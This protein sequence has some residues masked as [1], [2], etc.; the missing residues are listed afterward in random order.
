MSR[1]R[2][3]PFT[4]LLLAC[5]GLASVAPARGAFNDAFGVATSVTIAL[6]FFLH[7]ARLS[8]ATVI[9]GLTHW[10]LHLLVFASTFVLFPILGLAIGLF[11]PELLSPTLYAGILFLCALPSTV[12]SSIAF[13]SIARGNV[14]AAVCSAS[15]S[16][17][18]GIFLTPVLVSVLFSKHG[19]GEIS[20]AAI[21]SIMLQLL[22]PFV[23]GQIC[24]ARLSRL[25]Q[26]YKDLTGIVDRGSILMVVYL[27]FSNA[28]VGGL[29]QKLSVQSIAM[30]ALVDLALLL[31]VVAVTM[32][33]SRLLGFSKEDEITIVFCGSKKS[34]ASGL[35]MAAALFAGQDLGAIVLPLMIFHQIQ[36]LLCA[37]LARRYAKRATAPAEGRLSGG[38]A[39]PAVTAD[40]EVGEPG[41][42]SPSSCATAG[43]DTPAHV[44]VPADEKG[45]QM[46]C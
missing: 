25:L 37:V 5:V 17:I 44:I 19:S 30:L 28:V 20:L 4:I 14:P 2:P 38:A 43:R 33:A 46:R 9:A 18:I 42:S 39:H 6:L 11:A 21:E 13:T 41:S 8:R 34:L 10:R 45:Q 29:W 27:A 12:Q 15:A 1:L 32:G 3:D 7:G 35:P 36:L 22:L 24:Y 40:G 23:A 16:N 31:V 26:R